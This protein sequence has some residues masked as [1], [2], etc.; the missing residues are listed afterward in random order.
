MRAE[1]AGRGRA[2]GD[3]EDRV[4]QLRSQRGFT[5]IELLVVI[6]VLGLLVGLVGPRLFGRVGQSKTATTK[7]QIE[8]LGAGLD[9]YRLDVGS[10]PNTAQGLDALM[11]NPNA[12][13]WNGP[14]LK[15][16]VPKDPWGQPYKYA[17][18]PGQHGDYD[19]WSEG[20]D[21][22]PGGDGENADVTSWDQTAK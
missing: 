10:Y 14:Y 3:R 16:A 17:C 1:M 11:R 5:L 13:N 7:A 8:L 9:Q 2:S 15:K 22:A 19:L 4:R 21:N 6:I 20:A 12:P 18:C